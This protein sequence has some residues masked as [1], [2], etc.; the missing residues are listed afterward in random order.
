MHEV[1]SSGQ[2]EIICEPGFQVVCN[3]PPPIV[4]PTCDL[5]STFVTCKFDD[6]FLTYMSC[7]ERYLVCTNGGKVVNDV[8]PIY[9]KDDKEE[10]VTCSLGTIP[11]CNHPSK[12]LKDVGCVMEF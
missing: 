8:K 10:T 2:N 12:G 1:I 9:R 11:A 7:A 4:L 5:R 3:W 6:T